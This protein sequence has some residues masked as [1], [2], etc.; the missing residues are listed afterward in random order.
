MSSHNG[1]VV[2]WW[3]ACSFRPTKLLYTRFITSW[4]GDHLLLG[5]PSWYVTSHPAQLSLALPPWIGAMSNSLQGM[6]WMP[7]VAD[8]G[9]GMSAI[10]IV[11]PTVH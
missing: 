7:L 5:K 11:G 9:S 6:G 8:W 3:L 2:V 4:M 10:C 1:G